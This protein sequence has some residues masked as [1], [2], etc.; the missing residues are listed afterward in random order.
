MTET[1]RNQAKISCVRRDTSEEKLASVSHR[2]GISSNLVRLPLAKVVRGP[3]EWQRIRRSV[4]CY[5]RVRKRPLDCRI[6]Q[7]A[8][9]PGLPAQPLGQLRAKPHFR[10]GATG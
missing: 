9:S 7:G 2:H 5:H 1:K 8:V 4:P 3:A 10:P 6:S